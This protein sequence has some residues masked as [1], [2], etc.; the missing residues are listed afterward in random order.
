MP[1]DGECDVTPRS[2]QKRV[3]SEDGATHSCHHRSN[4]AY[5]LEGTGYFA[6]PVHTAVQARGRVDDVAR[7]DV[8]ALAEKV[9]A[10]KRET[11]PIRQYPELEILVD[12]ND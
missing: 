6:M 10:Q 8:A 12:S 5:Q 7:D 9:V 2:Q 4:P 3:I 11:R 1:A